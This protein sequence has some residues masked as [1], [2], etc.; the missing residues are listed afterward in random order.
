MFYALIKIRFKQLVRE[1]SGL[2][3]FRFLFFIGLMAFLGAMVFSV[4]GKTPHKFFVS[5]IVIL[6]VL[7]IHIQRRDRVFV[8]I[9]TLH[10]FKVYFAEYLLLSLPL[11]LSLACFHEWLVIIG[12][13]FGLIIISFIDYSPKSIT[14]NNRLIDL[15]PSASFEWKAGIR[16]VYWPIIIIWLAGI[17]GSFLVGV[18]PVSI[19]VLTF[20]IIGFYQDN[21]SVAILISQE[22]GAKLFLWKKIGSLQF[23][24]TIL[25]LPLLVLFFVFH[26]QIWYIPVIEYV[27]FSFVFIYTVLL[28]YAFYVPGVKTNINQT[29]AAFGPVS[30]LLPLLLPLVLLLSVKFYF[31]AKSN[32]K[33]YLDDYN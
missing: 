10:P 23:Q 19:V 4:L 26:P 32:L 28:K 17:L 25:L 3:I 18:V 13:I 31:N 33:I 1:F 5:G 22:S 12:F 14:R 11:V 2:G 20:I 21:E 8:K 24:F 27:V 15:I 30:I 6:L 29:L 9:L 16:K 7:G